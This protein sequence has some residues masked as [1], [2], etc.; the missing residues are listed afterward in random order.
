[1]TKILTDAVK[2]KNAALMH[3][4]EDSFSHYDDVYELQHY[5]T[6]ILKVRNKEVVEIRPVSN[7]SIRAINQALEYLGLS[8]TVKELKKN[9]LVQVIYEYWQSS[10]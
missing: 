10:Q 3:S 5:E 9:P 2:V 6:I 8:T 4:K 7:S 1:M